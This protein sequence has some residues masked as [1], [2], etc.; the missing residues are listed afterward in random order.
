MS[1]QK[2]YLC[3]TPFFPSPDNWRGAYVLDQIKAIQRNS[4][5]EVV[6]FMAREGEDY[7]ID[8]I[9]V[10]LYKS[11]ELPSN[12]L[13]G[14]FNVHNSKSFVKRVL[15]VGI[16]PQ[17]VDF[18]HC[19][20]SMR[21][22]CGLALKKL[23]PNIKVL[24]QHHDLDPFNLRSGV[25]GRYNRFNIRYKVRKALRLY[26]QV[27]LHICISESCRDSL[28]A[29]PNARNGEVFDDYLRVISKAIGMPHINPKDTYILYNGVDMSLFK[30]ENPEMRGERFEKEIFRI[31][32]IANFQELKDHITLIKAF[33]I[34]LKSLESRGEC[35]DNVRLSLLG[36]GETKE[37]CVKYL[38][39]HDLMR[40]V[41]WPKEVTHDKLPYYYRSLDLFVLP[42]YFEGF[43][44]VYTEAAA[45]GVPFM[46]CVNQGYSEYIHD[47]YNWLIEPKDYRQLAHNIERY[48]IDRKE[49]ILVHSYD[50]DT[51]ILEYINYIKKYDNTRY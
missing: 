51:L 36:S 49:Q 46:G 32:C 6:V 3:V 37:E 27:D 9:T 48:Y 39:E 23:N 34:F 35:L 17:D 20:V 13:N 7:Q 29:F 1:N 19:H 26:N 40:Y 24:L 16:N 8:G 22:A 33:E 50:I 25:I 10:H 38:T 21:A 15:E 45:C 30:G 11:R 28:L 2:Y 42:S 47:K 4:D 12:I 43:G 14:F 41:E 44:C 5:Y 31:G 18:V